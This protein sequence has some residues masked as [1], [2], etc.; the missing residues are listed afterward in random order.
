M[1]EVPVPEAK[2]WMVKAWRDLE[3]A[4]RA[5]TGEPPFYDVAAYHCQQAAEKAVKAI[6]V[7]H[8][9]AY[10]KTHDIEVL[11]EALEAAH[12]KG[13]IHRDLK[14]GNIKLMDDGRVK[15]LDFGLAKANDQLRRAGDAKSD[16]RH[17]P[18]HHRRPGDRIVRS[19]RPGK[20]KSEFRKYEIGCPASSV[21]SANR[22]GEPGAAGKGGFNHG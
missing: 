15:V 3:T 12:E 21:G 1:A 11:V 20:Q 16:P 2:A 19:C 4:R 13:I 9:R 22:P 18:A 8:G 10:E 14:P 5:V 7:H 17:P 6:L